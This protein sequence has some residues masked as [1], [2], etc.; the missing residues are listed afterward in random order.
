[1]DLN[2]C[3]ELTR[4]VHTIAYYTHL[5]PILASF[6]LA[7][8]LLIKTRGALL[9]KIFFYFVLGFN[10][11]LI[12]DIIVWTSQDYNLIAF[13]WSLFDYTN[14]LFFLFGL[15]F[16]VVLIHER[17]INW[18]WKMIGFLLTI[19]AFQRV[20]SWNAIHD[21]DQPT[22]GDNFGDIFLDIYKNWICILI[23]ILIIILMVRTTWKE[24]REMQRN[25]I[26]MVGTGIL[27]FFITFTGTDY[28]S[29]Q[30]N[31][32]EIGLYGLFILPVFLGLI[33]YAIVKYKAFNVGILAA[34][35][36]VVTLVVLIGAQFFF[37]EN[38]TNQILI[39]ITFLLV[40]IFGNYLIR[41]VKRDLE[42]RKQIEK[43]ASD[44]TKSNNQLE[45]ANLRLKELDQQKTEF[46]SLATHQIRGPLG[47]IKGHASLALEGDYGQIG[48]GA[49]KAFETIMSSAGSLVMVVND[50][51][52]VSRI[53]Q[54]NM[55]YDFSTF[56][57]KDL[58]KEVVNEFSPMLEKK[59]LTLDF[60]CDQSQ[61]YNVHADKGKIKQVMSN[62]IDNS[63]K[64]TLNGHVLVSVEK[65]A[66]KVLF[67][68]KD[69][70]V[71]I[72][73]DVLPNLFS[74]FSRAPDANK[75]NITG[76]GLGLFV[77][78]KIIE[79]HHGRI[80]AESEGENKGSQFYVELEERSG[81]SQ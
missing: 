4:D 26:L 69:S 53:E 54:G 14:I 41:S 59:S 71:G 28:L 12:F 6:F 76:T 22:C 63:I 42:T 30:T 10:I 73:S 57:L 5:V 47:A 50:Y 68:V 20:I 58:A 64:Y 44:L 43:S 2:T 72:K 48:E 37:I 36:L 80:W 67:S 33:V 61:T 18:K 29:V 55:K 24:K 32:Y 75:I 79:A 35:A 70:G 74:K 60:N 34:Q 8:Y 49:R 7:T 27:L 31:I 23:I 21:F 51:L 19:P 56:D 13:I 1:M 39:S 46:I 81:H 40:I 9:S 11:W 45:Q 15:Y 38:H 62:L 66:E 77:A 78:R 17:D 16:F 3:F 52:D 65:K 25:Q